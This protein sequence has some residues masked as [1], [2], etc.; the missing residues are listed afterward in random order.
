MPAGGDE[1]LPHQAADAARTGREDGDACHIPCRPCRRWCGRQLRPC[2][3]RGTQASSFK[4]AS[5]RRAP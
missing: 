5:R 2:T 4:W 3:A 1:R